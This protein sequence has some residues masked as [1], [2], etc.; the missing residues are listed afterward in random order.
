MAARVFTAF[1]YEHDEFLRTALVGQSRHKDTPFEIC[2]WSVKE[3][4]SGDWRKKVRERMRKCEQ[5][6]VMC[7]QYTNL[8]SGVRDELEIAQE[9]ELP[10]FLLK[11]YPD[12][13]CY[14]P[15]S[16]KATDKIYN[17]TWVNLKILIGGGR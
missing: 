6:I 4:F 13:T 7:G 1:D 5:V 14:K 15:T 17:W 11:G 3:P 2:D 12:K 10:Y 8:A 16:A 9:E